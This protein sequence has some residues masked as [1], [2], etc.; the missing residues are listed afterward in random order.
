M[1]L[2]VNHAWS[3]PQTPQSFYHVELHDNCTK[4]SLQMVLLLLSPSFSSIHCLDWEVVLA[5]NQELSQLKL[6]GPQGN[7]QII[8]HHVK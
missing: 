7:P 1:S 3:C 8:P 2:L 5:T 4:V 6:S